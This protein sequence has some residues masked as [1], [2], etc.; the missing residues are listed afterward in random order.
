MKI[1]LFTNTTFIRLAFGVIATGHFHF[2]DNETDD[3]SV[4]QSSPIGVKL[5]SYV[6]TFVEFILITQFLHRNQGE[7]SETTHF[8]LWFIQQKAV[9]VLIEEKSVHNMQPNYSFL[10][11]RKVVHISWIHIC[12]VLNAISTDLNVK[13]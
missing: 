5:F 6:N 13:K 2:R 4:Y 11:V 8:L 1:I 7:R 3:M 10:F 12:K 9:L